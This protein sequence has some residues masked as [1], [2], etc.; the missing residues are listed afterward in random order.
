MTASLHQAFERLPNRIKRFVRPS[1]R[2]RT[3]LTHMDA[4]RLGQSRI[5][6]QPDVPPRFKWPRYDGLPLSFIAQLN[7]ADFSDDLRVLPLPSQGSLAF[8]YDSEQRTWG[9]DPKDRGS[10]VVAYFPEPVA[11]LVRIEIPADVPE[12]G[13]FQSCALHYTPEQ[14]LPDAWSDYYVPQLSEDEK[15][16]LFDYQDAAAAESSGPCHRLG[17]HANCIQNPME[18]ECQLATNGLF[19]GDASGYDDPRAEILAPGALDWRLL[20]QVDTDDDAA[21]MWGDCGMIYF[22]IHEQDLRAAEFDRSWLI[23]QCGWDADDYEF[24][25]AKRP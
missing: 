1:L 20:L 9:F 21:M 10:A 15:D 17:G 3:T 14:S 23:L 11:S 19:C 2:I 8:F 13:R 6:G 7:L 16:L 25:F 22:W 5:G 4:I 12:M 18:I 24:V